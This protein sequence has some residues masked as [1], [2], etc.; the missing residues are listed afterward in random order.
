MSHQ[1]SCLNIT[2][3]TFPATSWTISH[4]CCVACCFH[5]QEIFS[6]TKLH[7][8]VIMAQIDKN[9]PLIFKKCFVVS[10]QYSMLLFVYIVVTPTVFYIILLSAVFSTTGSICLL[11]D[12]RDSVFGWQEAPPPPRAPLCVQSQQDTSSEIMGLFPGLI[13][14]FIAHVWAVRL[15]SNTLLWQACQGRLWRTN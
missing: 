7:L 8:C 14:S 11:Q 1:S 2:L 12:S 15:Y 5:F 6:Y 4:S 3:C 13:S 10:K 9:K